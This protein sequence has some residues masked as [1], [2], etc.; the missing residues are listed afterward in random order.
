MS[1]SKSRK[2]IILLIF[3]TDPPECTGVGIRLIKESIHC[4]VKA[5][6]TPETY[7]WH[8]Q[9]SNYE[10]QHLTTGSPT[11]SLDTITGPLAES[12]KAS[13]E[14]SNGIASQEESCDRVFSFEHLRPPQPEQCDIA[15]EFGEFQMKCIPGKF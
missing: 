8:L 11:L 12:L 14:A 1:S 7:F 9:P 2:F 15:Y 6:P 5:L 10:I 13:C 3:F 4:N